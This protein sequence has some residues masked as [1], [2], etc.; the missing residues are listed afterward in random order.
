MALLAMQTGG[1][2]SSTPSSNMGYINITPRAHAN[3]PASTMTRSSTSTDLY[4][5]IPPVPQSRLTEDATS[6]Q[7]A[8]V[9]N[10]QQVH[11]YTSHHK[12]I[13]LNVS[14]KKLHNRWFIILFFSS[15]FLL[16]WWSF[17][18]CQLLL[19]FWIAQNSRQNSSSKYLIRLQWQKIDWRV[20]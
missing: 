6:Q 19:D 13:L 8:L 17:I 20:V 2:Y 5:V 11:S 9:D 1:F 14:Q 4:K 7:T 12:R 3:F 18:R 10:T 15:S 16:S